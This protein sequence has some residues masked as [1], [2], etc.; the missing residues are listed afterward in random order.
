[1]QHSKRDLLSSCYYT[2][3]TDG[4]NTVAGLEWRAD[5][6]GNKPLKHLELR[7]RVGA[8]TQVRNCLRSWYTDGL[9]V[10]ISFVADSRKQEVLIG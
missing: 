6:Y 9:A 3:Q 2:I 8:V 7:A 4:S 5:D 1:M 10:G